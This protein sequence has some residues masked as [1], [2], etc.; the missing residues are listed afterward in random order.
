MNNKSLEKI[1]V[2]SPVKQDGGPTRAFE[3]QG[4]IGN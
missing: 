4:N 1:L 3:K 2:F